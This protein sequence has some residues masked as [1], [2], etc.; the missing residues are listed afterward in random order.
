MRDHAAK[1]A[2]FD[3][4]LE[5]MLDAIRDGV[6]QL[7]D[8]DE[9]NAIRNVWDH[10]RRQPAFGRNEA[11]MTVA[12]LAVRYHRGNTRLGLDCEGSS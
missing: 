4:E 11:I 6:S 3:Q 8:M 5:A 12:A 2:A 1:L 7:D 9:A 10:L